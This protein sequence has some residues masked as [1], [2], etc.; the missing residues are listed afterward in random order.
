[1]T[2]LKTKTALTARHT[3][4]TGSGQ[5]YEV[6]REKIL[7]LDLAPGTDLQESQLAEM[8]GGSRTPVREALI[9][10][11]A[12]GLVNLLPNRGAQVSIVAINDLRQYFESLDLLHRTTARWAA[13][14]RTS[15]GLAR[16]QAG[17][18]VFE[19]AAARRDTEVL[20]ETNQAFH[21][22]IAA[23]CDNSFV[24]SAYSHVTTF[25]MRLARIALTFNANSIEPFVG[26]VERIVAEHRQIYEHIAA[27]DPDGA[28]AAAGIH[29]QNGRDRVVQ[30]LTQFPPPENSPRRLDQWHRSV[31]GTKLS[32]RPHDKIRMPLRQLQERGR[33]G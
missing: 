14:R 10:L 30:L 8:V 18:K 33:Q 27:S 3:K 11:H 13:S 15:E 25:G 21:M 24:L 4:G 26:R 1:M 17:I 5:V 2:R 22:E 6:I 7:R 23:C 12:D 19:D 32:F 29:A 31:A 16:I 20:T 9:R 28:D